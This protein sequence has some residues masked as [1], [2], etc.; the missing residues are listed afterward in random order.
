MTKWLDMKSKPMSKL[1]L[2][3]TFDKGS[4]N[5]NE[6]E[7]LYPLL[8]SQVHLDNP[9]TLTWPLTAKIMPVDNINALNAATLPI[10]NGIVLS[11]LAEL[12]NKRHQDTRLK[13]AMDGFTM[14]ESAA[15]TILKANTMAILPENAKSPPNCLYLFIFQKHS[16]VK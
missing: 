15:T 1:L 2:D 4:R 10:S 12:A 14:T 5:P 7:S 6:S 13:H 3:L 8:L 9:I 16:K 11:I